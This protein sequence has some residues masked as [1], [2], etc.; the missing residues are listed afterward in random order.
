[1]NKWLLAPTTLLAAVL[2]AAAAP[3]AIK[4]ESHFAKLGTN[5]IH[6][7]TAGKGGPTIVFVHCWSGNASF[8]SEQVPALDDRARL[9]LIDLPGH[10]KS[11]KPRLAYTIGFFAEAVDA[12]MKDA[13]VTRATLVGHSMG[14]AVICGACK[15]TPEKI[16]ALV[17]VD[18]LLRRPDMKRDDIEK[19]I[20]PFRSQQYREHTTNFIKSMFPIPGV[21]AIRD[22]VIGEMLATP[23]HVMVSS[24]EG[25]FDQDQ[26][27]WNLGRVDIPVIA[28]N[29]PNPMWTDE[30]KAYVRGL[31]PKAEYHTID[32]VG[33]WLLLEKPKQFNGIFVEA[34]AKHGLIE[35]K[36]SP[37]KPQ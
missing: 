25:M 20:A 11:D 26:P 14:A 29:A 37:Q 16:A 6:Y 32:N 3:A 10:G 18:G 19:M 5:R 27:D 23:Q 9:I 24:M 36:P 2:A 34:L 4:G 21:E 33:H 17:P 30:Y 22:R 35:Q 8:W 1:M 13:N 7:V 15:R 12:V 31:S 28:I